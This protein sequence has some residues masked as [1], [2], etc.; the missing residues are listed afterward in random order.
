MWGVV[1][2]SPPDYYFL[3]ITTMADRKKTGKVM[4]RNILLMK[5]CGIFQE[6]SEGFVAFIDEDGNVTI[7]GDFTQTGHSDGQKMLFN[8]MRAIASSGFAPAADGSFTLATNL[9]SKTLLVP[10]TGLKVGDEIV[11]FKVLG[12]L[13]ATTA[14]ATV[15]DADLREV[16][17]GA[18]AVSDASVGAIT[19]VSVTADTALAAEKVLSAVKTVATGKQYYVLITATTAN[20]AAN[21]VAIIGVEVVVNRK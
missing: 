18:G 10:L 1:A 2:D 14:N 15:V 11:S 17:G 3:T 16:G 19:Q 7:P 8:S 13:G 12:A 21:D 4:N 9:S 5:K 6:T 20:N